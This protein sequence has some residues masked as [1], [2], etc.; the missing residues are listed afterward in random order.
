MIKL[1]N[2]MQKKCL[3]F[4]LMITGCRYS[5]QSK[6]FK[7]HYKV[8]PDY[9]ESNCSFDYSIVFEKITVDSIGADSVPA[10]Y[11]TKEIFT[12]GK[13]NL[14]D[15]SV[16]KINFYSPTTNYIWN[17]IKNSS[18]NPILPTTM[19]PNNW[20]LIR[21]LMVN[22]NPNGNVFIYV[23]A[24]GKYHFIHSSLKTAW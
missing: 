5:S 14:E 24:M 22:G 13:I 4:I 9:I 7:C 10:I 16:N 18:L 6:P 12:V 8:T 19:K 17:D 15:S 21:T 11:D 23:D 3:I 2:Y 20:Y 1:N